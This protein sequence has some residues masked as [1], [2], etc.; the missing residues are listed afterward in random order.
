MTEGVAGR[1]VVAVKVAVVN[2]DA[3]VKVALGRVAN[4]DRVVALVLGN[5][6]DQLAAGVDVAVQDVGDGVATLLAEHAA[7]EDSGDVLKLN[8]GINKARTDSVDNDNSVV[9]LGGDRLDKRVL[10]GV[11]ELLAV[12]TFARKRVQEDQ[13]DF[14]VLGV[15]GDGW[16][17]SCALA[18]VGESVTASAASRGATRTTSRAVGARA[19][20]ARAAGTVATSG[21]GRAHATA[22]RGRRVS[23]SVVQNPANHAAISSGPSRE[24]LEGGHEVGEGELAT[25]TS[26]CQMALVG[27]SARSLN[28]K[29]LVGAGH[30]RASVSTKD[31]DGPGA[32]Q[33]ETAAVG[34]VVFQEDQ[35]RRADL[36]DEGRVVGADVAVVGRA[37]FVGLLAV[38]EADEVVSNDVA[39]RHVVE[40]GLG[41]GAIADSGVQNIRGPERA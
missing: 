27:R 32:V 25:S 19:G 40:T 26:R 30:G 14:R 16:C 17:D 21:G 41:E 10:V 9:A 28:A 2:V 39:D 37:S 33:G 29:G 6:V 5:G 23:V 35:R 11:I 1:D 20:V 31:A 4:L 38:V 3:L 36:A 12:G 8:P 15:V 13:A 7:V 18:K 24:G 22:R 34:D